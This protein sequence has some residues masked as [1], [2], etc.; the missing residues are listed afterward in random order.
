LTSEFTF[1][2]RVIF[3]RRFGMCESFFVLDEGVIFYR[4]S[5]SYG[6]SRFSEALGSCRQSV[7]ISLS[8]C[9]FVQTCANLCEQKKRSSREVLFTRLSG[10]SHHEFSS[11]PDV[12]IEVGRFVQQSTPACDGFVCDRSQE[13]AP[14]AKDGWRS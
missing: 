14:L 6:N 9:E 4:A 5:S 11:P 2:A 7:R 12:S 3:R 13:L 1:F 10:A 8:F